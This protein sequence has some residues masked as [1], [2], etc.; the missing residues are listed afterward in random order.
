MS[1]YLLFNP[2]LNGMP[3]HTGNVKNFYFLLDIIKELTFVCDIN[4][5]S[6]LLKFAWT[7]QYLVFFNIFAEIF[8]I[9]NSREYEL[10]PVRAYWNDNGI[11][12]TFVVDIK[13]NKNCVFIVKDLNLLIKSVEKTKLVVNHWPQSIRGRNNYLSSELSCIDID[14]RDGL[15]RYCEH[16]VGLGLFYSFLF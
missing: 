12:N 1:D 7:Y 3:E 6:C 10:P 5:M 4:T 13:K 15:Y 11:N 8:Y 9:Y 2:S 14:V 16:N